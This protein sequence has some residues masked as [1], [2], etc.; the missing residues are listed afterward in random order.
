MSPIRHITLKS[1]QVGLS[2]LW[3]LYHLD[4]TLF[5][6]GVITGIMA[7]ELDSLQHLASI[8][9][10]ALSNMDFP[11]K[12]TEDNQKRISFA[13]NDSTMLIDLE[14]RS[15]PLHNLHISEWAFC[16]NSR[17][18]A[19]L[20]A[21][22]K[23]ANITGESTGNGMGNDFYGTWMDAKEGKNE[24]RYRFIPWY[25]HAEYSLPVVGLPSYKPDKREEMFHMEQSQIRFRRQMM[26]KLKSDFFIEYP[27]DELDCWGQSGSMFFDQRKI[28]ALARD[29]R[30][31]DNESPPFKDEEFYKIWEE[32]NKEHL[33]V[34]GADTAEGIDGDYSTF[35]V[36]C[37]HCRREAMAYRGHV[38]I[39]TFYKALDYWGRY[40]N[41][42]LLAVERNNHGHAVLLGL[43]ED[44]HYPNLYKEEK[45]KPIII[46]LS[47]PRDEA[48]LGWN[49]TANSKAIMLDALKIAVEGS[50]EE[51]ENTFH[52]EFHV[53]DL[54]FLSECL[55][56]QRNGNKIEAAQGKHDD[57]VIATAIAFQMYLK[58]RGQ[59]IGKNGLEK[60]VTG[61]P[62]TFS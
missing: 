13:H 31:M 2:T 10:F 39:D 15:T 9:K 18:W 42:C 55:T 5:K 22:S 11:V 49:T 57:T 44:C 41:R 48:K 30:E 36:I 14:F 51:D 45:E 16:E 33:Y 1:R 34:I 43:S 29:A 28:L 7:H 4:T 61:A 23:T 54:V 26:S 38:R 60:V 52:P 21:A 59:L 25:A 46:D 27:E 37:V 20:A 32:P 3:I 35:K 58:T 40:Y 12:L 53:R 17:I 6:Q 24:Y 19:T 62:R 47:R 56:M 50:A 8:V